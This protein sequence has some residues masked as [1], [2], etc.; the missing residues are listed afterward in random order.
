MPVDVS[1]KIKDKMVIFITV[2]SEGN[3]FCLADCDLSES[4]RETFQHT[5]KL[6]WN[7]K[8]EPNTSNQRAMSQIIYSAYLSRKKNERT[9]FE[10]RNSW[11]LLT[12]V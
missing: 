1:F 5:N 4:S 10:D 12:A 9:V 2:T 3:T 7:S 11:F 8:I 6:P